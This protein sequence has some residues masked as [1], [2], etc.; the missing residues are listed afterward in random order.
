MLPRFKEVPHIFIDKQ[1][2][3]NTRLKPGKIS[4]GIRLSLQLAYLLFCFTLLRMLANEFLVLVVI[5]FKGYV[6]VL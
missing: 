2:N 3:L 1:T 4:E 5:Y 6:E